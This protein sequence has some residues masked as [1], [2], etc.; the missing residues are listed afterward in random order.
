MNKHI[1]I[2]LVSTLAMLGIFSISAGIMYSK[3]ESKNIEQKILVVVEYKQINK[4]EPINIKPK[5]ITIEANTPLSIKTIDYLDVAVSDEILKELKL[6]TS[7]VNVTAV[8]TY[9]YTIEHNKKTYNGIIIVKPQTIANKV[10]TITL[11]PINIKL[12]TPLQT[13]ISY[14]VIEQLNDFDKSNMVIDLSNVNI[15]QA[16]TYQYSITYNQS[17]Y[18]GNITVTEDQ[19]TL[20]SGIPETKEENKETEIPNTNNEEINN[21]DQNINQTT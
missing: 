12:G 10:Q 6:D 11:K 17:I 2:I 13:D 18:T 4:K 19:P 15:N 7:S 21:T 3:L 16:G 5:T 20:S 9:N 14:Y 8:G 1:R